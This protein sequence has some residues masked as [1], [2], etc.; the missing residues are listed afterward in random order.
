MEN[1][2]APGVRSEPGGHR[3]SGRGPDLPDA[4]FLFVDMINFS[5]LMVCT[6]HRFVE[7]IR[8]SHVGEQ[9]TGMNGGIGNLEELKG[10]SD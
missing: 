7:F 4:H 1:S 5:C 3:A 10:V 6:Q 8:L 9:L 2:D